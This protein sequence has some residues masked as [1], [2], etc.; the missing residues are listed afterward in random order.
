MA[1]ACCDQCKYQWRVAADLPGRQVRSPKCTCVVSETA[2]LLFSTQSREN[3]AKADSESSARL[4]VSNIVRRCDT[5]SLLQVELRARWEMIGQNELLSD[6]AS[7]GKFS[8]CFDG[9]VVARQC[10]HPCEHYAAR[11]LDSCTAFVTP[12]RVK[13]LSI[14]RKFQD[15]W[16]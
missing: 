14:L 16:S 11:P 15:Y 9:A 5:V 4:H 1:Y 13:T 3:P 2:E 10:Q 7:V 12:A 6:V 8:Q